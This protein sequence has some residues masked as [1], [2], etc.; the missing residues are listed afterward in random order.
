M[1]LYL[2]RE[3]KAEVKEIEKN[4]KKTR[5]IRVAKEQAI[6]KDLIAKD[7]KCA[8]CSRT[9]NLTLD[10]IV[11]RDILLTFGI[12]PDREIIEGNYQIL[13]KT[14]NIYKSRRLDFSIPQTKEILLRLLEKL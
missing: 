13:C 6:F 2:Y 7:R 1:N 4:E 9:E 12:D 5:A 11:P 10:H 3:L 14:C 8:K